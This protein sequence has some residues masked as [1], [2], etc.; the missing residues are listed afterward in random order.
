MPA[1]LGS[2]EQ[3]LSFKR[4]FLRLFFTALRSVAGARCFGKSDSRGI[5]Q[6]CTA[7]QQNF[8]EL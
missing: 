2:L 5:A 3:R 7:L 1:E 8:R 6:S 4:G